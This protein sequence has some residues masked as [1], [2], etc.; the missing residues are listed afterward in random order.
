MVEMK[1]K[2]EKLSSQKLKKLERD[3]A[4]V[5][6]AENYLTKEREKLVKEKEKIGVKIRKEKEILNLKNKI[7][8]IEGK[9]G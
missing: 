1:T 6:K 8:R 2:V 5:E 7:K 4:K 9:R 3:L